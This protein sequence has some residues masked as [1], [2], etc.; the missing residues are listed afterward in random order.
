VKGVIK[1]ESKVDYGIPIVGYPDY[2]ITEDGC[3]YSFLSDRFLKHYQRSDGYVVVS[4]R[5]RKGAKRTCYIHRLVAE[6]FITNTDDTKTEVNHKDLD[7]TNNHYTNLEWVSSLQN[8]RHAI[9]NNVGVDKH[10]CLRKHL[11]TIR[12]LYKQ[13]YSQYKLA[14]MFN[15]NQSNISRV[16]NYK[17]YQGGDGD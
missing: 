12:T 13:G 5:S 7:K 9:A 17:R 15:V 4:L 10:G 2:L 1:I 14:E 6:A 3:V 11:D 16:V 8:T